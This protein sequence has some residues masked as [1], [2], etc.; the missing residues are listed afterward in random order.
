MAQAYSNKP[1]S[2]LDRHLE[3]KSFVGFEVDS[4]QVSIACTN[5]W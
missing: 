2:C 4:V 5:E 3:V 1:N